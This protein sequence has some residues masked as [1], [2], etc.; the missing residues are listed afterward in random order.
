MKTF[1]A[2]DGTSFIHD[3][4][5]VGRVVVI[6]PPSRPMVP[7][8]EIDGCALVEFVAHLVAADRATKLEEQSPRE[9]LGL[10]PLE[11]APRFAFAGED[12][13]FEDEHR[14]LFAD[15]EGDRR[16]G[17]DRR[18]PGRTIGDQARRRPGGG[19]CRPRTSRPTIRRSWMRVFERSPPAWGSPLICSPPIWATIVGEATARESGPRWAMQDQAIDGVSRGIEESR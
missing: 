10:D 9:L 5:A 6:A 1:T 4:D 3:T 17:R 12:P 2:S 16:G 15:R 19:R 13:R 8:L 11:E 7:P 18:A 14:P